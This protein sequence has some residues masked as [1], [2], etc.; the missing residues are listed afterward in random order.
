MI[1]IH[2]EHP[3]LFEDYRVT[4]GL[5]KALGASYAEL[6]EEVAGWLK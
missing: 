6:A 1:E 2:Q 5:V 4:Q 3:E